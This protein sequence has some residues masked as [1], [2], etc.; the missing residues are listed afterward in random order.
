MTTAPSGRTSRKR[1]T[2]VERELPKGLPLR[3]RLRD[4]PEPRLEGDVE[5]IDEVHGHRVVQ[6]GVRTSGLGRPGVERP[7]ERLGDGAEIDPRSAVGG[8]DGGRRGP[9][10]PRGDRVT[11]R[12]GRDATVPSSAAVGAVIPST[13]GEMVGGRS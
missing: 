5:D 6:H 8:H 1:R 3:E 11:C 4:C 7:E 10:S 12:C 13:G 9:R 2:A